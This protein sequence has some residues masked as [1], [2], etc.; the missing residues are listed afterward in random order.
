MPG[1]ARRVASRQAQLGRK[2]KR[3]QKPDNNARPPEPVAT[4]LDGQQ[5]ESAIPQVPAPPT[6]TPKSA[7]A[8][9][10]P[11]PVAARATQT[12]STPTPARTRGERP[13]SYNY[14]GREMRRILVLT[15]AVL[16]IIIVLGIIL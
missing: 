2:K 12:A 16:A 15:A 14:V 4:E 10:R 6:P 3:Q 7:P 8:P 13:A 11:S 1:K 5:A 9:A